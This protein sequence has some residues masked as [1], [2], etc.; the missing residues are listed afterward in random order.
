MSPRERYPGRTYGQLTN[1]MW[2]SV[3]CA[4]IGNDI[5]HYSGQNV[6]LKRRSVFHHSIQRQRK[7]LFQS[8]TISDWFISRNERFWLAFTTRESWGKQRCRDYYRQRKISQSDCEITSNCGENRPYSR[9]P[10]C[11]ICYFHAN[12]Y[13]F[14][15]GQTTQVRKVITNI[16]ATQMICFAFI[17]FL[18]PK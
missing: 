4:L 1:R 14:L 9:W 13:T 2:F 17:E 12:Y 8:V 11:W 15:R 3:V 7:C 5:R 6:G 18:S 16:L 10:P